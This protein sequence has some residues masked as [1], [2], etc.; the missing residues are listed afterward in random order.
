[1]KLGRSIIAILALSTMIFYIVRPTIVFSYYTIDPKGFIERF[2]ENKDKPKMHCDGKCQL[3]KVTKSSDTNSQ[4]EPKIELTRELTYCL[5]TKTTYQFPFHKPI[6]IQETAYRNS[7]SYQN[8][9]CIFHPP[10][11]IL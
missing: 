3:K 6:S 4:N 1:M 5:P 9:Q 8:A 11:G 10:N 7:Y 2:C